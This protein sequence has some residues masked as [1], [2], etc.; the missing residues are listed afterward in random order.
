MLVLDVT[1]SMGD[2][3]STATQKIVALRDA[4]MALYDELRADPDPARSERHAAALRRR[5]LFDARSTSA[6]LIRDVNPDYIADKR[7][8]TSRAWPITTISRSTISRRCSR[9]SPGRRR[10]MRARSRN[11]T[12][13][14]MAATSAFSGF[15]PSATTGGGPA[16]TDDL[17]PHLLE[18]R[19]RPASTGAGRASDTSGSNRTCRRRYVQTNTS[20]T[21][22]YYYRSS[23]YTYQE[24]PVDVSD[25]KMGGPITIATDRRRPGRGRRQLRPASDLPT[26]RDRR[27]HDHRCDL[28]RL[29]RGARD[30]R[31]DHDHLGLHHP[32][33]RLRPPHQ[34]HP[35]QRRDALAADDPGALLRAGR[36][37]NDSVW[38]RALPG[39]GAAAGARGPLGNMQTYVNGLLPTGNTYH[40][41][42]MIWGARMISNAR[43]LRR[44]P[45]HVQRHAGRRAT[46]SS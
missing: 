20:Y 17:D 30:R 14:N 5:A 3:L 15:S 13:T 21:A 18:Q 12:A 24:E 42:G 27:G 41:T 34:P 45:R 32:E 7:R 8:P 6:A 4:V 16:P 40:D 38:H 26:R 9:R 10:P 19:D 29:H 36:L 33:R 11:R 23:G 25:Y 39:R 35:D 43:H 28:E 37:G 46:S 22:N 31:H 2:R 44:Q 1:G